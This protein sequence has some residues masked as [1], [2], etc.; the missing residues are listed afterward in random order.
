MTISIAT[1]ISIPALFQSY[2]I[3]LQFLR[4]RHSSVS[5]KMYFELCAV[6]SN[7]G[8][9]LCA[10]YASMWFQEEL[11]Q[12]RDIW[13]LRLFC[14]DSHSAKKEGNGFWRMKYRNHDFGGVIICFWKPR[15]TSLPVGNS[16]WSLCIYGPQSHWGH[17]RSGVLILKPTCL[18]KS[19]DTGL[20]ETGVEESRQVQ[21][22]SCNH[23]QINIP[24][25]FESE[26]RNS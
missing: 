2:P 23:P 9:E 6:F 8:F 11:S 7:C 14:R 10:I 17:L 12:F 3:C 18:W 24:I 22:K 25:Y 4:I 13:R 19:Q 26:P 5:F 16:R 15:K 1:A 21:D 20:C